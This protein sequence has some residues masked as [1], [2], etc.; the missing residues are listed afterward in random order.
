MDLG[1]FI[2]SKRVL[3][4]W[5]MTPPVLLAAMRVAADSYVAYTET[6]LAR[7]RALVDLVPRMEQATSAARETIRKLSPPPRSSEYSHGLNE[8]IAEFAQTQNVVLNSFGTQPA[9]DSGAGLHFGMSV[10][11]PLFALA[12]FMNRLQGAEPLLTIRKA[13]I[14]VLNLRT[15][16]PAYRCETLLSVHRRAPPGSGVSNGLAPGAKTGAVENE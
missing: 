7:G 2:R 16:E 5:L 9:G 3:A 6:R 4:I 12:T 1:K 10:E 15:N 11:A 14:S 13:Q 8:R